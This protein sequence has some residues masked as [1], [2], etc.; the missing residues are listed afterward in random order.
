[1]IFS[2]VKNM[3]V[4]LCAAVALSGCTSVS[5]HVDFKKI[6]PNDRVYMGNV[7]VRLNEKPVLKCELYVG[8][9]IV[10]SVKLSP[11]GYLVYRTSGKAFRLSS[12]ACPLDVGAGKVVWLVHSLDDLEFSRPESK[13]QMGYFGH[14]TLAWTYDPSE[15]NGRLPPLMVRSSD[16]S[17]VP[18][19]KDLG[20]IKVER[21]SLLSEATAYAQSHW[22]SLAAL[23]VVDLTKP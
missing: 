23:T 19:L 20:E 18:R 4:A 15:L 16:T 22:S 8:S 12:L 11:D 7:Q 9:D 1:M 5:N 3:V 13:D 6:K 2:N 10:P 21:Q 17:S 14:L